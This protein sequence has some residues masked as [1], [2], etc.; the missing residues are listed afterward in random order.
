MFELTDD[1]VTTI[2]L[3]NGFKLKEQSDGT[4]ALNPYVITCIKTAV[5]A[6]DV[7]R[8]PKEFIQKVRYIASTLR[9]S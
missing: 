9:I 3:A 8:K 4:M 2:A 7:K 1:E 5:K 6:N